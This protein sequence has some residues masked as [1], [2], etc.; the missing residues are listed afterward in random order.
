MRISRI[1]L[2]LA[3]A[4]VAV[5]IGLEGVA[6][7]APLPRP[8]GPRPAPPKPPSSP[9]Y[10][11]DNINE[12]QPAVFGYTNC[13]GF[14]GVKKSGYLTNDQS[15]T[16]TQRNGDVQTFRCHGGV[17][18]TPTSV[19]PARCSKVG[20]IPSAQAPAPVPYSGQ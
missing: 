3:G 15:Y 18:D 10:I 20:T 6:G 16:L 2:P 14:G 1:L 13:Q 19:A 9:T 8:A 7:A 5:V 17:V 11:C 4:V 12:L